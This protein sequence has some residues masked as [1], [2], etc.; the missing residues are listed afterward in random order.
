[1]ANDNVLA[2]KQAPNEKPP[3]PPMYRIIEMA[4][5]FFAIGVNIGIDATNG[6]ILWAGGSPTHFD[7]FNDAVAGIHKLVAARK[8]HFDKHGNALDSVS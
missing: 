3:E 1:M 6:E 2:F 7:T 5:G 4:N 8:W